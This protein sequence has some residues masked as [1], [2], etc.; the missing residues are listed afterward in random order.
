[1]NK[2]FINSSYVW[3]PIILLVDLDTLLVIRSLNKSFEKQV[4]SWGKCHQEVKSIKEG[5]NL[6]KLAKNITYEVKPFFKYDLKDNQDAT[7]LP[8]VTDDIFMGYSVGSRWFNITNS[9]MYIC[10]DSTQDNAVWVDTTGPSD[11]MTSQR[12][13]V[14]VW[15]WTTYDQDTES[16]ANHF[17]SGVFD[18]RR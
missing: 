12:D 3:I 4:Y 5:E 13:T 6:Q 16:Q 15:Q 14:G 18:P 2:N 1:M 17:I 8:S 11:L 9:R 10:T 7:T